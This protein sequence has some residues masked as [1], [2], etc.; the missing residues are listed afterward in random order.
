MSRFARNALVALISF[1]AGAGL[2]VLMIWKG[3]SLAR[4][5]LVGRFYYVLLIPIGLSAAIFLFGVLRSYAVL[6]G[7][8]MGTAYEL[9]G[10]IVAALLVVGGGFCLVEP[11]QADFALTVYVHGPAG[12]QDLILSGT[13]EVL[14]DLGRERKTAPIDDLGRGYFPTVSAR[15]RGKEVAVSVLAEG[16]ASTGSREALVFGHALSFGSKECGDRPGEGD[17]LGDGKPFGGGNDPHR[18]DAGAFRPNRLV[19]SGDSG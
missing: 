6:K 9:G 15:F 10:P 1:L 3:D 4:L 13:G 18:V 8:H 14:V 16:Y 7:R 2:L 19:P 12:P 17:R 5:G 11:D